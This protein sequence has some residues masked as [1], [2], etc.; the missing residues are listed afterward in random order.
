[1][2]LE[3]NDG[4]SPRVSLNDLG[5]ETH[6]AGQP[7]LRE[8]AD[9]IWFAPRNKSSLFGRWP[10]QDVK[11]LSLQAGGNYCAVGWRSGD[12][13]RWQL[14]VQLSETGQRVVVV[15]TNSRWWRLG[16]RRGRSVWTAT[17]SW[18]LALVNWV[19]SA[20]VVVLCLAPDRELN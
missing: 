4:F 14:C 7:A 1:M 9:T 17:V 12:H 2:G 6:R 20:L 11:E 8:T 15:K 19:A 18:D 16:T 13:T 10:S 3:P 5:S